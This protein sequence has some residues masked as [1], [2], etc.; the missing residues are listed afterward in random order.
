MDKQNIP[1]HIF[2]FEL[3]SFLLIKKIYKKNDRIAMF[4]IHLKLLEKVNRQVIR[5]IGSMN[6]RNLCYTSI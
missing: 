1:R 6:D 5:N 4:L 3:D 2:Y